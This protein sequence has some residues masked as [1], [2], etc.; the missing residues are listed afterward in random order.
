[1]SVASDNREKLIAENINKL[2]IPGLTAVRPVADVRL[3]DVQT[4]FKFKEAWI[5]V[6]MNHTD[7]LGNVRIA[8]DGKKWVTSERDGI[9]PLKKFMVNL[10]NSGAGKA[11]ADIFLNELARFVG[12]KTKADIT[13]PTTKGGLSHPNAISRDN[14]QKF[15]RAKGNQYFI[16][17]PRVDLGKLVTDHYNAGKMKPVSYLQAADD[18]YMF[19]DL[20]ALGLRRFHPDIPK[21]VGTGSF[22]LR[23]GV[24]TEFYELQPEIKILDMKSSPY[25][26]L[27]INYDSASNRKKNPFEGLK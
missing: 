4:K 26:I 20:D 6:K 23:V 22:R 8:W 14:M 1:M 24:R 16:N 17:V 25:S 12:K 21:V 9:T 18:F 27:N 3:A 7:N 19:G 2:N 10:L 5:E 15:L 13:V 11:Q